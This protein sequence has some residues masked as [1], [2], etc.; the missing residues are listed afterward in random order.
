[1]S[2]TYTI[3]DPERQLITWI[4]EEYATN[5]QTNESI[6]LILHNLKHEAPLVIFPHN[7]LVTLFNVAFHTVVKQLGVRD[8]IY[9]DNKMPLLPKWLQPTKC[10]DN[11]I[12]SLR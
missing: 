4:I 11:L 1:M 9:L 7:Q 2:V 3:D 8:L 12:M 6:Q 5:Q 10:V